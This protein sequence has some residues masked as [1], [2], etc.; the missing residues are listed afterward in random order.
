MPKSNTLRKKQKEKNEKLNEKL[1]ERIE[2][3]R[4]RR[5]EEDSLGDSLKNYFEELKRPS[6]DWLKGSKISSERYEM[7][8]LS[9]QKM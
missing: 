3:R 8:L 2:K 6:T 1:I 9:L 5:K 7:P 4:K